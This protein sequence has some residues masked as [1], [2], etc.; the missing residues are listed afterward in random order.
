MVRF[1]GLWRG[2]I[3]CPHCLIPYSTRVSK[4]MRVGTWEIAP[5]SLMDELFWAF[6]LSIRAS[7]A[8]SLDP[9]PQDPGV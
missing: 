3:Q 9:Q 5:C 7:E 4:E 6:L 1:K 2:N 8:L